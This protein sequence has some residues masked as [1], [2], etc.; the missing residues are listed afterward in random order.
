[1]ANGIFDRFKVIDTD[2]HITE[3]HD[4]W[5]SR[6]ASKWGDLVPHIRKVDGRDFWMIGD[7]TCGGPGFYT[8]AGFDGTFPDVP[9]GYDDIP[10]S[11]YDAKAR[12]AMMDEEGIYA[13]VLYPNLGGFGSGGFLRLKEPKLMLEFVAVHYERFFFIQNNSEMVSPSASNPVVVK[14]IV[15]SVSLTFDGR[16]PY[17]E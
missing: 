10:A 16:P 17:S 11:S 15:K 7:E 2:T 8:M 14:R 4:V 5:T 6:V 9:T 1:M 12:L 3:P 13:Q